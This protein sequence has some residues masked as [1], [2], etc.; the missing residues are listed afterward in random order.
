[1]TVPHL[2]FGQIGNYP[3]NPEDKKFKASYIP[4]YETCSLPEHC[5]LSQ[6]QL[7]IPTK[8]AV[9]ILLSKT[10]SI[11]VCWE[12]LNCVRLNTFDGYKEMGLRVPNNVSLEI[13]TSLR[14]LGSPHDIYQSA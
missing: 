9:N 8:T 13:H 4:S 3:N 5:S 1:M 14:F 6:N 7:D 12:C 2:V 10:Q 11:L